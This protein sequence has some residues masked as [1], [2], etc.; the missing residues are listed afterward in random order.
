MCAQVW[1]FL[2]NGTSNYFVTFDYVFNLKMAG[3]GENLKQEGPHGIKALYCIK[4]DV[5]ADLT[6]N[7]LAA[8]FVFAQHCSVNH[9]RLFALSHLMQ[10]TRASSACSIAAGAASEQPKAGLAQ[11]PKMLIAPD[12]AAIVHILHV[13]AAQVCINVQLKCAT[14]CHL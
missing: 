1:V 9:N 13:R 2:N 5:S 6:F 7:M 4:F 3:N 11:A 14:I 12:C 8:G 10:Q